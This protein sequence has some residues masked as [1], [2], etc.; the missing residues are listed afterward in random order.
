MSKLLLSLIFF[1]FLIPFSI[2]ISPFLLPTSSRHQPINVLHV[3]E[4]DFHYQFICLHEFKRIMLLVDVV[5]AYVRRFDAHFVQ[6]MSS[7]WFTNDLIQNPVSL[8]I[9]EFLFVLFVCL[10]TYES[11]YWTGIYLGLWE[12]HAKEIFTE[13]PVHCA[14]VYV[15]INFAR[16]A[17]LDKVK[18]YYKLKHDSTYNILN[19]KRLNELGQDTFGLQKFVKYHFEFSPEDFENNPEPE[20]GSTIEHLRE[21]ILDTIH[22]SSVYS[23]FKKDKQIFSKEDVFLLNNKTIEVGHESDKVYLSKIHIETGNVIDAVVVY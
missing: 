17:D 15:R 19:W 7:H 22:E 18:Q 12:Y 4:S 23:E 20:F 6:I 9:S 13:V 14:H 10:L 11:I 16:K 3:S 5:T 1:Q 2:Q 8:V 21:K